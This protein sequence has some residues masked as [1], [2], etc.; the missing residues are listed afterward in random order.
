MGGLIYI[1]VRSIF[2]NCSYDDRILAACEKFFDSLSS[3]GRSAACILDDIAGDLY[4][5]IAVPGICGHVQG[6]SAQKA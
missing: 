2:S 6:I 4:D 5:R 3:V 1:S